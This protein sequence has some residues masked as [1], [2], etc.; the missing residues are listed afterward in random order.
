MKVPE[1]LFS[2]D[3]AKIR[4]WRRRESLRITL[5][6]RPDLLAKAELS[7]EDQRFLD[8]LRKRE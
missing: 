4:E 8:E 1:I 6:N 3:H 2:G 7:A 5:Q